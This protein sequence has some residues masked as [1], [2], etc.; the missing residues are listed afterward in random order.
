ML[1]TA[2]DF[3]F[4]VIALFVLLACFT[5][6]GVPFAYGSAAAT[7]PAAPGSP[8]ASPPAVSPGASPAAQDP[9][10]GLAPSNAAETSA[11]FGD[12]ANWNQ[13]GSGPELKQL[14]PANWRGGPKDRDEAFG[15]LSIDPERVRQSQRSMGLVRLPQSSRGTMSRSLGQTSLIRE[16][17]T[18]LSSVPVGK[19]NFFSHDSERRLSSIYEATGS[20]PNDLCC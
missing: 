5:K 3:C 14:M 4:V 2:I 18:P 6:D 12:G 16:A 19:S 7:R 15:R 9:L 10:Q 20:Y 17:V 8:K 11:S 1:P 13:G